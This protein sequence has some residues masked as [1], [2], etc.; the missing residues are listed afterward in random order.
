M[1]VLGSGEPQ[2]RNFEFDQIVAQ[3][4]GGGIEDSN[5]LAGQALIEFLEGPT[6]GFDVLL[7]VERAK[8]HASLPRVRQG[9]HWQIVLRGSGRRGDQTPVH[10]S[11]HG[12]HV[13]ARGDR[14]VGDEHGFHFRQKPAEN[15]SD[16]EPID[17]V[18]VA[19][20]LHPFEPKFVIPVLDKVQ[21][22][23]FPVHDA[24]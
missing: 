14:R 16:I 18:D 22:G 1:A 4:R 19:A 3:P 21:A 12:S 6:V 11:Q 23:L 20:F 9:A 17:L 10:R 5:R 24:L 15:L 7:P 8:V 2:N 13:D